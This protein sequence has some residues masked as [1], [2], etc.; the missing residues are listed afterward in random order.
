MKFITNMK[1]KSGELAP[2][3]F[4]QNIVSGLRNES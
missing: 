2:P 3:N 1:C 4:K